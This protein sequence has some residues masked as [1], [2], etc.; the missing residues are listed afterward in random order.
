ME[1]YQKIEK[2]GEGRV[3]NAAQARGFFELDGPL[4]SLKLLIDALYTR[5]LWCGLQS[6]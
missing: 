6:S 4:E 5:N 3:P 2:I 1:N